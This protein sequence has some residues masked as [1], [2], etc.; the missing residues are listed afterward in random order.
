MY[1][2]PSTVR[3]LSVYDMMWW[4]RHALL[5]ISIL[6]RLSS[7]HPIDMNMLFVL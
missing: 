7:S 5:T 1:W 3:S 4:A 2:L 6:H